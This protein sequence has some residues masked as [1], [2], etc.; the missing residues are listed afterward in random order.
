MK[1]HLKLEPH[2]IAGSNIACWYERNEGI[3]IFVAMKH[4]TRCLRFHGTNSV[5]R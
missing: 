1:Q 2:T 3:E 5:K 4:G